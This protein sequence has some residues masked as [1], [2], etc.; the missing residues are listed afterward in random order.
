MGH[1]DTACGTI[2]GEKLIITNEIITNTRQ[3]IAMFHTVNN[4]Y[5][6]AFG[7]QTNLCH[8]VNKVN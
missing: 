1:K 2:L 5:K 3:F 7:G 6:N 4:K 8:C